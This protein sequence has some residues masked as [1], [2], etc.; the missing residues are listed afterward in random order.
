[1]KPPLCPWCQNP[2]V[3][4]IVWENGCPKHAEISCMWCGYCEIE[5]GPQKEKAG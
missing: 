4:G 5:A 3:V 1:M 2:T